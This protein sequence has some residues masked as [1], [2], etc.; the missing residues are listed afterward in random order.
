[1]PSVAIV[2]LTAVL[3][4]L[5]WDWRLALVAL[6]VQY[7]AAGLLFVDILDPRLIMVKW[8]VGLFVCLILLITGLQIR[9]GK[10]PPDLTADEV[11][12]LPDERT[13]T[14]GGLNLPA[15]AL[16]RLVSTLVLALVILLVAPR[17]DVSLPGVPDVVSYL[18]IA[19][20]SLVG[21]GLLGVV[22]SRHPFP[23]GFSLFTFMTGFELYFGVLDTAVET[24]AILAGVNLV[25]AIAIAYLSQRRQA[26]LYALVS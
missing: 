18:N 16:L 24:L 4:T 23:A 15:N 1:M 22:L 17:P 21:F 7:F 6:A 10:L 11:A 8:I 12:R 5:F 13:I 19:I 25:L 14:V 3:I 2:L 20:L 9:Y 26:R